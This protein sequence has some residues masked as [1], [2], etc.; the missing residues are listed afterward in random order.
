MIYVDPSLIIEPIR[1]RLSP[2]R[3]ELWL[4]CPAR[5]GYSELEGH[6]E[7]DNEAT[8]LGTATH[9]EH[10]LYFGPQHRPYQTGTRAGLLAWQMA[11]KYPDRRDFVAWGGRVEEELTHTVEGI[12]LEGRL[13]MNWLHGGVAFVGDHK[14]TKHMRWAKLDRS[15]LFGHAQAPFYCLVA[16]EKW[17]VDRARTQWVYA[18]TQMAV[19]SL[20]VSAHNISK[21]EA[22]E[23]TYVR[24]LPVVKQM[25]AARD[26]HVSADDLP[27][28]TRA[29][30]KYNRPCPHIERCKPERY[31]VSEMSF[32]DDLKAE[33][34]AGATTQ[35]NATTA[36]TPPATGGG[37]FD[38]PP[39]Q[40]PTTPALADPGD[41]EPAGDAPVNPPEGKEGG[42]GKGRRGAGE[43]GATK[44]SEAD[45]D[46]LAERV[47]DK[48]WARLGRGVQ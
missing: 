19:A 40:P 28:N 42:R 45:I 32:L 13:D 9:L 23:R 1:I 10:E 31:R 11:H 46:A 14:T 24:M 18:T 34:G 29:C 21:E 26:A 38:T 37:L 20:E 8:L 6:K 5:W 3:V 48:L 16:C 30:W 41:D 27:K 35:P 7:P 43:K 36:V 12:T 47:I 4:T 44:L 2:S 17:N 39:A 25:I 15:D 33:A 22:R